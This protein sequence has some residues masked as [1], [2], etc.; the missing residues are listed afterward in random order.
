MK[1]YGGTNVPNPITVYNAT[2]N[3]VLPIPTYTGYTFGGWYENDM[4]TG[5]QIITTLTRKQC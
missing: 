1:Q 2:T 5:S 4:L 3:A